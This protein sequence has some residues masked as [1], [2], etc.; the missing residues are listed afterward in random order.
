M[1]RF[2]GLSFRVITIVCILWNTTKFNY[3]HSLL[4]IVAVIVISHMY[5]K[6]AE[7]GTK[8]SAVVADEEYTAGFTATP[9]L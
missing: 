4:A 2:L 7:K 9:L 3:Q 8:A 6:D 1:I 5:I